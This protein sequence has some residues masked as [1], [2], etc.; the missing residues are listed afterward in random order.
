MG[1]AHHREEA[2]RLIRSLPRSLVRVLE[3]PVL[4]VDFN[5]LAMTQT[6]LDY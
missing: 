3:G 1:Q 4:P 6:L 2:Q 5:F